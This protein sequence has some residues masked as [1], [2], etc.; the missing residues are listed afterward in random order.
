[1]PWSYRRF[2]LCKDMGW[3][4]DVFDAQTLPDLAEFEA[5]AA[6]DGEAA[7]Q[8]LQRFDTTST[9]TNGAGGGDKHAQRMAA[10]KQKVRAHRQRARS[11]KRGH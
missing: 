9:S 10:H 11:W 8:Q 5:W 1:M 4:P 2:R 6:I 7:Q 3:S